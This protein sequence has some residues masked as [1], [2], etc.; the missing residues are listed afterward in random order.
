[1]SNDKPFTARKSPASAWK[2]IE[3]LRIDRSGVVM[4][5]P[6]A[7]WISMLAAIQGV[8][9]RPRRWP[10]SGVA[11]RRKYRAGGREAHGR[12]RGQALQETFAERPH[13]FVVDE[14]MREQAGRL[15]VR[16]GS[17]RDAAGQVRDER[18]RIG[19]TAAGAPGNRV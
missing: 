7:S 1:M 19:E 5:W 10:A 3:R 6:W 17:A 12:M 11:S 18:V 16:L 14:M 9:Q 8:E 15:R 4:P 2:S 13:G